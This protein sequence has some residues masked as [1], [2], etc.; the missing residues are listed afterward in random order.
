LLRDVP[1]L[2]HIYECFNHQEGVFVTQA[3]TGYDFKNNIATITMDRDEKRNAFNEAMSSEVLAHIDKAE[4]SGARVI[5]LRG[6]PG[7]KVW[8]S[9]HDL[10]ELNPGATFDFTQGLMEKLVKRI[11]SVPIPFISMVEGEVYAG[12]LLITMAS[13]IVIAAENTSLSMTANKIG[14]PFPTGIY[15]YWLRICGIHKA[16]ELLFTASPISAQDAYIAGFFNHV[17]PL[18]KLERFTYEVIARSII[19][20]S[21]EGIRNAKL[22]LNLLAE[23]ACLTSNEKKVIEADLNR[24]T[25]NPDFKRRV[26]GLLTRIHKHNSEQ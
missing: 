11:Q 2:S 9:G 25:N 5:V 3:F 1:L 26:D 16:K 10:T 21:E 22:Q 6:N 18:Q 12:G 14:L 7:L 8:C 13:D 20:C 15:A 23:S 19:Q 17:V 24:L 4:K